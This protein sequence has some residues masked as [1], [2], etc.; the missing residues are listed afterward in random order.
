MPWI[1]YAISAFALLSMIL[2][3][4]CCASPAAVTGI[5]KDSKC[6]LDENEDGVVTQEEDERYREC[7]EEEERRRRAAST[8]S[9]FFGSATMAEARPAFGELTFHTLVGKS[10]KPSKRGAEGHVPLL[11]Q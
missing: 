5:E 3:I 11:S 10:P 8:A 7:R 1:L 4:C 6:K 2:L 9:S